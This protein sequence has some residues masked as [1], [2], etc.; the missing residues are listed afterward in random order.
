MEYLHIPSVIC[1]HLFPALHDFAPTDLIFKHSVLFISYLETG[2][3]TNENLAAC[4][5]MKACCCIWV[6]S[7]HCCSE[8][9]DNSN[10]QENCEFWVDHFLPYLTGNFEQRFHLPTFHGTL[11]VRI[12]TDCESDLVTLHSHFQILPLDYSHHHVL[13]PAAPLALSSPATTLKALEASIMNV[14]AHLPQLASKK[15]FEAAFSFWWYAK[16]VAKIRKSEKKGSIE[17]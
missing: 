3:F 13:P 17:V 14:C 11:V 1:H 6:L 16:G 7:C 10:Q 8:L 9:N 15:L 12:F 5:C 4:L 2:C